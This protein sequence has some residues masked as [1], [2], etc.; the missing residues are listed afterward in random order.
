MG[1]A[2][3]KAKEDWLKEE[4]QSEEFTVMEV[5]RGNIS[6]SREWPRATERSRKIKP[7]VSPGFIDKEVMGVSMRGIILKRKGRWGFQ[8]PAQGRK[9]TS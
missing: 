6:R 8:G 9:G 4:G 1:D 3:I 5:M 7:E 2:G